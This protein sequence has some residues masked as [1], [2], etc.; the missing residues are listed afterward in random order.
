[1]QLQMTEQVRIFLDRCGQRL[2][3]VKAKELAD[4]IGGSFSTLDWLVIRKH[5]SGYTMQVL[6]AQKSIERAKTFM[7]WVAVALYVNGAYRIRAYE[8]LERI[9]P[10]PEEFRLFQEEVALRRSRNGKKTRL[11]NI[12]LHISRVEAREQNAAL[13]A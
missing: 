10:T 6:A 5:S 12:A 13:A 1:M 3:R 7:E 4:A 9:R 2:S 8:E 11:E